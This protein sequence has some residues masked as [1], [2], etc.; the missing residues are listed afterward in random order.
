[1][2]A[3]ALILVEGLPGSGKSTAAQR[4]WLH[5]EALGRPARWWFEHELGHPI[6]DDDAVRAARETGPAE[7][8]RIFERALEGWRALAGRPP[9]A[10]TAVLDGTLFQVTVGTQ[11]LMDVPAEE[12]QAHFRRTV[13]ILAPVAPAL[14]RFRQPDTEA[15]LRRAFARRPGWFEAFVTRQFA[16]T[17]RGR[18]IGRNDVGAVAEYF[19]E[20]EEMTDALC[21][22]FPGPEL[23]W[24]D[25]S[26]DWKARERAVAEFLG[27]AP[28][29][30]AALSAP[31]EDYAGRFRAETGDEWA[32]AAE[33]GGVRFADEART[34]LLPHGRDAFVIEGL[35]VELA[36]RRDRRG[37][38][39]EIDC[40][41]ALPGLARRW[42]KVSAG[43]P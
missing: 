38:V 27:L 22:E 15:A 9:A 19:R 3:G 37:A 8:G 6:F 1:M 33:D 18:R 32:L 40:R 34:R 24:D 20:R 36:F 31:A 41:G 28:V 39:S 12:I 14:V 5:L 11:L 25:S 43:G 7:P 42:R 29:A 2:A 13:E 16:A 26:G 23:V 21:A 4:I 35:C 17:P 30:A 10:G